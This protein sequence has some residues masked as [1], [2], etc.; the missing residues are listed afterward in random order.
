MTICK[1]YPISYKVDILEANFSQ[2]INTAFIIATTALIFYHMTRVKSLLMKPLNAAIICNG[3]LLSSFMF[4]TFG[5]YNYFNRINYLKKI[6]NNN[7]CIVDILNKSQI[8][9][10]FISLN[11][12][13]LI[14]F[15]LIRIVINTK[16]YFKFK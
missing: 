6:N 10:S 5:Y 4:I 7:K 2:S 11:I 16:K 1:N 3:L 13:V 9:Y 14:L 8:I 15:I 12:C